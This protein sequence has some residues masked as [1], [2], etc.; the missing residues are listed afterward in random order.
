MSKG[1]VLNVAAFGLTALALV[2]SAVAQAAPQAEAPLPEG[3]GKAV[4]QK[5]CVGCHK[6]SVITSKRATPEQW[7]NIVQQMVSR[8]ADGT[9][10]EIDTVTRYLS[11]NF[12]PQA[13]DKPATPPPAP[14]S[15]SLGARFYAPLPTR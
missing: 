14:P 12:P 2:S 7:A 13:D 4:I 9:D 15:I 11:T 8:G 6:I 5:M 10:E 3:P 1:R